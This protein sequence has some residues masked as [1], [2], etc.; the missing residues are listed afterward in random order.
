MRFASTAWV[1]AAAW[2]TG[3]TGGAGDAPVAADSGGPAKTHDDETPRGPRGGRLLR[4]GAF[5]LEVG[6]DEGGGAPRFE[7]Y[8][9]R[10]GDPLP[11]DGI[12]VMLVT[13][14]LDGERERFELGVEEDALVSESLV[15][16]PHSFEVAVTARADG[17]EHRWVFENV[18]G[19]TIIPADTA[20]ASGITVAEAGPATIVEQVELTGTIQ[21]VPSGM[22]D[23][24]ARF[25]GVVREIRRDVGDLVAAGE[26]LAVVENN[27]SLRDFEVVAPIDGTI[28]ERIAQV[29]QVT[30]GETMF[31]LVNADRVWAQLDVFG[32]D[33]ARIATGQRAALRTL[34]GHVATGVVEWLSPLVAHGS[35]SLRARVPL[36][37]ADR[38]LRPGQFVRASVVVAEAD[39]PLAV[40]IAGLQ[41]FREFDVVFERIG[42][43]YEVRMLELGRRDDDFAEVL[44]GLRAGA[45]YVV[46]NSYLIKADIE[47]SGASHD[48]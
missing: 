14:R 48:H 3:C 6:I 30:D 26:V 7:A 38:R 32:G 2:L 10:D 8:A 4:D 21:A 18:E 42:D 37:N 12:D 5:A 47:K 16:E 40:D 27:E 13:T 44:G 41:R 11:A 19:R 34:D 45:E 9:Y 39:V 29:G 25:P 33:V 15:P 31:R 35:Q 17:S 46:G 1:L 36:D 24:R 28:V 43:A 20:A 23:V 22:A